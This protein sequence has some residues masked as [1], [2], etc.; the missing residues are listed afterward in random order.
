MKETD[1]IIA[2]YPFATCQSSL[3]FNLDDV[4][5]SK[6]IF[7]LEDRNIIPA[8]QVNLLCTAI[9]KKCKRYTV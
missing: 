2:W 1:M 9:S 5:F 6:M 8:F 3:K 7:C 4:S